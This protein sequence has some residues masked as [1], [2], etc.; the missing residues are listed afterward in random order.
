LLIRVV[1]KIAL[2]TNIVNSD[3][4]IPVVIIGVHEDTAVTEGDKP[5]ALPNLSQ[6]YSANPYVLIDAFFFGFLCLL[7][8][9][10]NGDAQFPSSASIIRIISR[11]AFSNERFTWRRFAIVQFT[12]ICTNCLCL[13]K[14]RKSR[15]KKSTLNGGEKRSRI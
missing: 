4:T 6:P 12:M 8:I 10:L 3:V 2:V 11:V 15:F 14:K 13:K 5:W 9:S 1:Y 7:S